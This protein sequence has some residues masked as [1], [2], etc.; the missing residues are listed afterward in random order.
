MVGL[1][2]APAVLAK[3][4]SARM[5]TGLDIRALTWGTDDDTLL[6]VGLLAQWNGLDA[7]TPSRARLAAA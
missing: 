4:R 7:D 5:K 2:R 3:V 6:R 1:T